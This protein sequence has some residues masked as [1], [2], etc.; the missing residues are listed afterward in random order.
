MRSELAGSR[1]EQH[2][3]HD[4]GPTI[5]LESLGRS[6]GPSVYHRDF[7]AAGGLSILISDGELDYC[8][9]Q[10]SRPIMP[11]PSIKC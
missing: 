7:I 4:E 3:E 8:P 2:A 1:Y 10:L 5:P 11:M 6:N 9:D